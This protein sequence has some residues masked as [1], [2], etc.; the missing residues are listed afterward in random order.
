M[1]SFI[2]YTETLGFP[3]CSLAMVWEVVKH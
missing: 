3:Q 1:H 2:C